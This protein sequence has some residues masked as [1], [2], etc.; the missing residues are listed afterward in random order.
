MTKARTRQ[1]I[2][3]F[4]TFLLAA[5]AIGYLFFPSVMLSIVG[6]R[7][8]SQIDF[9]VRTLAAAFIAM[10]PSTWSVRK[11]NNSSLHRSVILGLAIYMFLSSTVDL[12]AFLIH[13]VS[14]VSIPSILFR[15]LLGAVL[16]WLLP[17]SNESP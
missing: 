12:H 15:V 2:S 9:L 6:I 13:L 4:I 16:L 17:H 14:A 1:A 10:I 3:I 8:N 5:S 11:N 7:S